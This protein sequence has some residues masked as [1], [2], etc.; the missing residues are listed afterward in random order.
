MFPSLAARE[1]FVVK[2]YKFCCWKQE[3]VSASGQ[4]TLLLPG[5]TTFASEKYVAQFSHRG[6]N[7][8]YFPVLLIENVSLTLT[9]ISS[10]SEAQIQH[11]GSL[12]GC[13][14]IKNPVK[15]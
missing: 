12:V 6:S 10:L 5:H 4:K 15:Q 7:V 1:T 13:K 9:K 2:D 8:D 14:I 3:N 11:T